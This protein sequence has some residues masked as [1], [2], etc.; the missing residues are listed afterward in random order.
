VNASLPKDE[1]IEIHPH[2]LRHT[3]LRKLAKRDIRLAREVSGLKS[4]KYL[5]R[6]IKATEEEVEEGLTGLWE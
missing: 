3:S 5:W 2:L 1:Q 6:Y 4:D